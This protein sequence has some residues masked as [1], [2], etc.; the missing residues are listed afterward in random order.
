MFQNSVT[1]SPDSRHLAYISRIGPHFRVWY[2]GV[3][4]TTYEG[5]TRQSPFFSPQKNRLAFIAQEDEKMFAVIDGKP[6]GKYAQVGTFTFAPDG[7]RFAYRV[8]NEE[9]EQFVIIDKKKGPD[10]PVGVTPEIGIIFSPDSRHVAYVGINENGSHILVRDH[11]KID[12]YDKISDIRFSPDSKHIAAICKEK[13]RWMVVKDGRKGDPYQQVGNLRFSPDAKHIAYTAKKNN[14]MIIVLDQKELDEG[15]GAIS[16]VFSPDGRRFAYIT[17]DAEE[18]CRYV[19]DGKKGMTI[20]RPGR[21]IF[22]HDSS[23]VAYGAWIGGKWYII[24]DGQ[25]GPAFEKILFFS[26]SPYSSDLVYGGKKEDGQACIVTNDQPG[27]TYQAVMVPVFSPDKETLAY[28]AITKED[29]M[30]MVVNGE[31]QKPY[32]AIGIP[33]ESGEDGLTFTAKQ[34]FFSPDGKRLAYPVFT[35]EKE[36]F[37]VVDGQEHPRFE[38]VGRPYFSPDGTHIAY[39]AYQDG[40]SLVVIDGIASENR[41]DGIP[42]DATLTFADD[43]HCYLLVVQETDP[44]PSFFRLDIEIQ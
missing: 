33:H 37:M 20:G 12:G 18:K 8:E 40:K 16:P 19:I 28:A 42:R 41:F 36:A 17:I 1:V 3:A 25:K 38:T 4:E 35:E 43:N 21:L 34:P 27:K 7:S 26:F 13:D 29:K 2:D 39:T 5:V 31:E 44:G 9:G 30:V 11:K 10:F 32:A 15:K 22:S 14:K 24:S 23:R 6:Q